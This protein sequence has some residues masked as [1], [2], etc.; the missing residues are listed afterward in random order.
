VD[1]ERVVAWFGTQ[2]VAA[3]DVQGKQLWRAD[4]GI[5]KHTWGYGASPIIYGNDVFL[6]FGPGVRSFLIAL[7]KRTGKETWRKDIAPGKGN[8]FGN[9]SPEDMYGSWSTPVMVER[10]GSPELLLSLPRRL[11]AFHPADGRELWSAGGL[12]DLIYPSPVPGEEGIV[13]ASGFGGPMIAV[14][15]GGERLWHVEKGRSM[16]GSPVITGGHF[17]MV[18]NN[19]IVHCLKL[20]TGETVWSQRLQD[21]DDNGVWSSPVLHQGKVYVMNKSGRVHAFA[22]Q[23]KYESLGTWSLD[24]PANAS[25][26]LVDGVLYL[27]TDKALWAIGARR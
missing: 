11:V 25:V 7:D 22:A 17:Y 13:A 23:P 15:A 4:L 26:V 5:Q 20:A 2:G 21:S 27:R 3:F 18:D 9:W 12:G 6:N 10:G 14:K 19:G 8:A 24:E 16:I 1:G